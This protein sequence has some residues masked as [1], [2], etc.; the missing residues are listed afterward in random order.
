[1]DWMAQV[2]DGGEAG[3]LIMPSYY[4]VY[5]Q[6]NRLWKLSQGALLP[7]SCPWSSS[8]EPSMGGGGNR[9]PL[10]RCCL[11]REEMRKY[12][13]FRRSRDEQGFPP[14]LAPAGQSPTDVARL[15]SRQ[16]GNSPEA[17]RVGPWLP[18]AAVSFRKVA[19]MIPLTLESPSPW[20]G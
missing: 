2:V 10:L 8:T 11:L 20:E 15:N 1:M 14:S 17:V 6:R 9:V 12:R 4:G 18:R 3:P 13:R 16:P 5:F 7:K 19:A